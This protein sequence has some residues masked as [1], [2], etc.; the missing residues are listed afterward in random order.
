MAAQAVVALR[1]GTL[2]GEITHH[3]WTVALLA[4]AVFLA[5]ALG[6]PTEEMLQDTL[7]SIVVSFAAL[8]AAALFFWHQRQR[9]EP[10]RW[11]ALMWLPLLLTVY[12]L[13]SM[14]WSHT[15][16]AAVEA[17][18]WFIFSLVL[19]LGLNTISRER[20]PLLAWGVH[21]GAVVASLWAVLQ[22]LVDFRLFPQGPNPASTFVNRNFFAEFVV[23]T[24]PFSALLLL[25]A[26]QSGM[27]ALLS[28]STGLVL[29]SILMTGTRSAL[30]AMWLQLLVILPVI[31]WLFRRQLAISRWSHARRALAI[32]LLL[33][34]VVG[35]GIIPS[36]N[37][38][39]QQ[40]QRGSTGLERGLKRTAAITSDDAS[41]D[42][43]KVMWQATLRMIKDR[44]FSGVGAGAW[45]SEIPLYQVSGAQLETDFYAHN[46]F[47][48]LL[49]E[50]GLAGWAF[51]VSLFAYLVAAAWRTASDKTQ[52]ALAEAPMRSMVLCSVLALF[53][54]SNVGFPWR[55]ASTGALF[56]VCLAALAASDARLGLI[57]RS[58]AMA[59]RWSPALA[60]AAGLVTAACIALALY[61]TQQAAL[62]EQKI[63]KATKIALGISGTG[64]YNNPK[65]D[66][67]KVQMLQLMREG[68]EM[69]PH[70]RKITPLVGDE[71]AR[72]GDW[73]NAIW[74]WES[75]LS[76][77]PFV[78]A[79]ISN[80]ARGYASIGDT[81]KALDYL[82]RARRLQ[83]DAPAV[84]SLEVILL[85]RSGHDA[86][87]LRLAREALQHQVIDYDLLR[88]TV[89]LARRAGDRSLA[90]NALELL[91]DGWPQ[92]RR[93]AYLELGNLYSL[94][95]HDEGISL[96][97]FRKALE[98]T[99][100]ASRQAL[101]SQI[102]ASA[103]S[104][105]APTGSAPTGS[106][107]MSVISK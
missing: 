77:R 21:A 88:A 74:I 64:D 94:E 38:K 12:A 105:L 50:Y 53:M 103:W 2:P 106:T 31:A 99:P 15:Y 32:G 100:L 96:E 28:V 85:M 40:E 55:M 22:F 49:A 47:L 98:L 66:G 80:V 42:I 4:L 16:L 17:I 18:R 57:G 95:P 26:R 72:W 90:V 11:H 81:P 30:S 1:A 20:L 86:E 70:Y 67:Y 25:R 107:Q 5:P 63:V 23:C 27:I 43:R 13:G 34:T 62:S 14:A 56:A 54:V 76:S 84:R 71:L 48:Q 46:E 45:E 89:T 101:Q 10:L 79:I 104:R 58:G 78:V 59:L 87:A 19:W 61:V 51:L 83:P 69:N 82:E 7:K 68:I 3:D 35:L 39:I 97:A 36:A 93:W 52:P 41:I 75:V 37:T 91:I 73:R 8:A 102:P 65:Y 29:V 9:S 24:L 6:V 44:P 60:R 92:A 33:L